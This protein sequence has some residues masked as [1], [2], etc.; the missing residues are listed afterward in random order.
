MNTLALDLIT[1]CY[2]TKDLYLDLGMCGLTD[3]DFR[4]G[5][6][7]DIA[8]R[9][10]NHLEHFILS[11]KWVE[12]NEKFGVWER[13]RSTNQ[14]KKN[15]FT[16]YPPALEQLS[17]LTTLLCNG[18]FD[19]EW[20]IS[21]ISFVQ[22]FHKIKRLDL[23]HN[24]ITE[25]KDL[26]AL[27]ALQKFHI[28]N[29]S[30]TELKGLDYLAALQE[31]NIS[32]NWI[33]EI[34][35]LDSLTA[36]QTFDMSDNRIAELKGLDSLAALQIFHISQNQI[37]E[38]KGLDFLIA[39]QAFDIS[40]NNIVELKGLDSLVTLQAFNISNNQITELK[41]L[42]AL[43][44][45]R[46]FDISYNR[47]SELKG[48]E[49]LAVL[50]TF[51]ISYNKIEELKNLESLTGLQ[52]FDISDN[53]I[54][55]LKDIDLPAGLQALDVS[56]NK[57]EDI[58]PLLKPF[59]LRKEFPLRI[60]V[61]DGELI[62]PGEINVEDN[63][64]RRPPMEI[65][66]QGNNVI[67]YWCAAEDQGKSVNHETKI[68]LF[69]NGRSGKTSLSLRLRKNKFIPLT[70]KDRTHGILIKTWNIP[71]KELPGKLKRRIAENLR[72]SNMD[73]PM[74]IMKPNSFQIHLWDFG[75]QEYYHATHRLFMSNNIL[76]LLIWETATNR[77]YENEEQEQFDY[78]VN[79]WQK[80]INHFSQRNITLCI[81]NK[82]KKQADRT[83]DLHYKIEWRD[84][85]DQKSIN[86][87]ENDIEVLKEAILDHLTNFS[88]IGELSPLVYDKIKQALRKVQSKYIGYADYKKLC[89]ANDTT[90]GRIMQEDAQK[91]TLIRFLDDTGAVVCFRFRKGVET[92][93]LKEYVFTNPVW[94]TSIIYKILEKKK[95]EFDRQHVEKIVLNDGLDATLWIGIMKQFELIFEIEENNE[96]RYVVP[97]YLPD[98]CI[99]QKAYKMTMAGKKM[100][101][102]FTLNYPGFLPKSN[103]L[104]LLAKYGKQSISYLYWKK[105]MLFF[106]NEKTVF[107]ECIIT[108]E[109]RK[110]VITVQDKDEAVAKEIF[111]TLL[112]IDDAEDLQ[113]SVNEK[114]FVEVKKL[115]EKISK[116]NAEI[117]SAEGNTLLV[118]SFNILFANKDES[119]YS[120]HTAV[121]KEINIF[122]SY[123]SKDRDIRKLLVSGLKEHLANRD[124]FDFHF[125]DDTAIDMGA[126]W[127]ENI[128]NALKKSDA[129]ILLVSASFAASDFIQKNEFGE[130][131]KRKTENEYLIMPVL[132]RDYNFLANSR[133][134]VFNFFKTYYNEYGFNDP[135]KDKVLIPF[136]ELTNQRE[137]NKYYRKLADFIETAVKNHFK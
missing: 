15:Y 129:A 14:S 119:T 5:S 78:P 55:E 130:F 114:D 96:K 3:E 132:V 102:A 59:V 109:I 84:E 81:Q 121:T 50:Q 113:V 118:N 43:T 46:T 82:V 70:E 10:C 71:A 23:S 36:L 73:S 47:I 122:V 91:E 26:A 18:D 56:G 87:Y 19:T 124:S 28:Y 128:E 137:L 1:K 98:T 29:N 44:A 112:E 2:D 13:K 110:I 40:N 33:R 77:Q 17:N 41:G 131:L 45:L 48:L 93:A 62:K 24:E 94:L 105:G 42:D 117:D 21:D 120:K 111:K 134:S 88:Y 92:S 31:F 115:K 83:D 123:S 6:T 103:F 4:V 57:I 37:K 35:G 51:H 86:R 64:I 25:L 135:L 69:G 101:H 107:A 20:K 30:I 108:K 9:K 65:V 66:Y 54:E 125:W 116:N 100:E 80:N 34:K 61:K 106:H 75:G 49:S 38:L 60:V 39:L 85:N 63:P 52:T 74:G 11:N 76:Y 126:D 136:D 27:T 90:P 89:E 104:R 8:L 97:Q 99:D 133:L 12:W 68:I 95:A 58:T 53:R 67:L 72:E 16:T 79:Y 32:H 7:L 22:N 127:K